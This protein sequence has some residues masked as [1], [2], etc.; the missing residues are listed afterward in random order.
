MAL[1]CLLAAAALDKEH[2][3]VH[4]QIIRFKLALDQGAKTLS[5]QSADVIKSEFTLLPAGADLTKY[6]DEYLLKHSECS[7]RTVSALKVRKL[8]S[9]DSA[10]AVEKDVVGV[11]DLPSI[12]LEEAKEAFALLGSWKSKEVEAFRLL[13]EA[14]W[15]KAS[16]FAAP[17]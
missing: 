1:K 13:A 15:P 9:P 11:L 10:S 17:A 3:K 12:T 4:E 6:N 8:L 5:P 2:S 14:K 7:R 16:V